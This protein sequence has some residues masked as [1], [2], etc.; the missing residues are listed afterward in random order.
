MKFIKILLLLLAAS[1]TFAAEAPA[2]PDKLITYQLV[3]L[4]KGPK[5][6]TAATPEG[7]QLLGQHLEHLYKLNQQGVFKVAGQFTDRGEIQG[8]V[9]VAAAT[10]AEA[11]QLEGTDPAVQAGIFSME[12][13][14]F[15]S[16]PDWFGKWVQSPRRTFER[17]FFGFLVRGPNRGQDAETAKRMQAEHLAYMDGQSQLGKLV[18]AGPITE[19]SARRGIVVYRVATPEEAKERAEADPM[20]KAGR[21]QVEL[22]SWAVPVGALPA[23]KTSQ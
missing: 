14:P 16:P 8:V 7:Q 17:V 19:E 20:V 9:F 1:A 21:L 13:M 6:A 11:L 23:A 3:L 4:K 2:T 12:A 18:V 10:P 5:A 22:H 15:L